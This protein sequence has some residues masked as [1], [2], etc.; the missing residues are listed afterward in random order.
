MFTAI[1]MSSPPE[2]IFRLLEVACSF[3]VCPELLPPLVA[4]P[5]FLP[6]GT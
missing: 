6:R 2:I 1:R 4:I 5:Q 3:G